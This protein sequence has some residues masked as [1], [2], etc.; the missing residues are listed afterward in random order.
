MLCSCM[1]LIHNHAVSIKK[2]TALYSVRDSHNL[3]IGQ[4]KIELPY[5]TQEQRYQPLTTRYA[6]KNVE[7]KGIQFYLLQTMQ[8]LWVKD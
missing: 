7:T 4:K 2:V 8:Y 5:L 3:T 1:R 6:Y